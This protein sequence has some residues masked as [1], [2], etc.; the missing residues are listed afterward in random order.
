M[1]SQEQER[2]MQDLDE[3]TVTEAALAQ[4]ANTP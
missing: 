4:M 1:P 2:P 3:N